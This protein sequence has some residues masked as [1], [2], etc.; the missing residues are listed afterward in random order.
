MNRLALA[1]VDVRSRPR[2]H[3][4][5]AL[6]R[7][8]NCKETQRRASH[9]SQKYCGNRNRGPKQ[10]FYL[11]Q[12]RKKAKCSICRG[13]NTRYCVNDLIPTRLKLEANIASAKVL[14]RDQLG[15]CAQIWLTFRDSSKTH[16]DRPLFFHRF[17]G[18][19]DFPAPISSSS[20]VAWSQEG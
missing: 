17:Q 11:A 10:L 6:C 19:K 5:E 9:I 12:E 4:E 3:G 18:G 13:H 2:R 15:L 20:F 8:R 7:K 14:F 1:F 16:T